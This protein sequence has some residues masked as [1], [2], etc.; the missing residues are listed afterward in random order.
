[1]DQIGLLRLFFSNEAHSLKQKGSGDMV[2]GKKVTGKAMSFPAGVGLGVVVSL[3]VSTALCA[4][5]TW[6]VLGNA[7]AETSIG[8]VSMGVLFL[9]ASLGAVVA[10]AKVKRRR[11]LVCLLTGGAF[12]TM[13]LAT[14]AIFFGGQYQGA[15][16]SVITVLAGSM[17]AGM[18]SLKRKEGYKK[19][20]TRIKAC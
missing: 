14:T 5:L 2:T 12:L 19:R 16:V 10:S 17:G 3:V 4:A 20:R 11:M 6:L 7:V 13:L 15:G 18:L 1:V 8:Y 9:A